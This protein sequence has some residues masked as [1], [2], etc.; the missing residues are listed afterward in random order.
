MGCCGS[1]EP[2]PEEHKPGCYENFCTRGEQTPS[3]KLVFLQDL[4]LK[5]L[6]KRMMLRQMGMAVADRLVQLV[7]APV[8]RVSLIVMLA[9]WVRGLGRALRLEK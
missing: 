3:G 6:E 1:S 5:L 2:P 4:F 8:I 9:L 7:L